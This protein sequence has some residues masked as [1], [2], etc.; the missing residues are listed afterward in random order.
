MDL[1]KKDALI[2]NAARGGVIDEQAIKIAN[3]NPNNLIFDV[4]E[5]EPNIDSEFAT[6]LFISTPHIAGHSFEG[7]LRGTLNM[8]QSLELYLGKRIDKSLIIN[9]INN[10]EKSQLTSLNTNDLFEKL[11]SNIQLSKT[12]TDFK[13][14]LDDFDYK[15]F[16]QMRKE[17][18]KHNETLSEDS[19]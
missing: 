19:F 12:S 16:N 8:L 1:V 18:P 14:I 7:K 6:S 10:F 13:R 15:K 2:I 11:E 4:W 3:H 9:E 17:Y 5:N